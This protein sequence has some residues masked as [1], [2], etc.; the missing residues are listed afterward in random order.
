MLRLVTE[1][2]ALMCV[3]ETFLDK[4]TGEVKLEGY[5]VVARRDRHD[6][7][8]WGGVLV[9]AK[10]ELADSV[11]ALENSDSEERVWLSVHSDHGPYLVGVWYR[12]PN[13]GYTAGEW[14]LSKRSLK[15]TGRQTWEY[16]L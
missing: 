12:A 4:S 10:E 14:T 7:S 9:F 16:W 2:P 11:A 13:P 15:N 3:T 5:K 8:G 6:N 1:K